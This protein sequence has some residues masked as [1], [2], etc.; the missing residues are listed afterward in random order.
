MYFFK[1]MIAENCYQHIYIAPKT[2][3][4]NCKKRIKNVTEM[5]T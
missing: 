5:Q 3:K 1:E 4:N 2:E